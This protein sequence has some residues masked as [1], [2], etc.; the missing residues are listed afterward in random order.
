MVRG[1]PSEDLKGKTLLGIIAQRLCGQH[2][3]AG[4]SNQKKSALSGRE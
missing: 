3:D 1:F 4:F 2:E